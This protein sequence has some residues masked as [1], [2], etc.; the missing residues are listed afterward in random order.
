MIGRLRIG[1]V[2]RAGDAAVALLPKPFRER[3]RGGEGVAG[4]AQTVEIVM[5]DWSQTVPLL[6]DEDLF[7]GSGDPGTVFEKWLSGSH[8]DPARTQQTGTELE[9]K[10]Q[11]KEK[12][13]GAG[14][15]Q[16]CQGANQGMPD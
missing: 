11:V 6:T 2:E 5:T 3:L 1:L 7:G 8:T 9:V 13:Q 12:Q 16:D 14:D 15:A 10:E 4:R